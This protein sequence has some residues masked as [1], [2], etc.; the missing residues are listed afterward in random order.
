[1]TPPVTHIS[2]PRPGLAMLLLL[3]LAVPLAAP[4]WAQ[5]RII[6]PACRQQCNAPARE[7]AAN[8]PAVQACLIR[9]Q[10]GSDFTRGMNA[11][12]RRAL[13]T[14]VATAPTSGTWAV[15]YA[16]TPPNGTTGTSQGLHDR[17]QA[18]MEAERACAARA[19][20]HCRPLA[21]AGP[22]ECVAASQA[23]RVTGLM[24]TADPRTFQVTLVEYGKGA[25]PAEAG[26]AAM[27]ACSGRAQ[28][29]LVTT[30]CGRR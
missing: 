28:C 30:V 8:P 10:A 29:E 11:A 27:A 9:C 21:E 16:A 7:L 24:R 15:I 6:A 1:M 20:S 22:G 5:T 19:G 26:R 3:L 2:I 18:H 14:T 12:P 25:D 4:A 23:G 13:G 17:N